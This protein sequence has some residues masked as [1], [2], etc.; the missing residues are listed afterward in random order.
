MSDPPAKLDADSVRAAW[1]RAA[2]AYVSGQSSGRD[3]YRGD[4]FGPIQAALCGDVADL[5]LLDVG[6]GSGY[7]AREM[8]RRGAR[9]TA[10][11]ISPRMIEHAR[12][13]E[14]L[15][16]LSI[17]YEVLD[18]AQIATVWPAGSFDMATS[19]VALQ[20]MANVD[21]VLSAVHDVLRPGGRFVASITHPCTTTPHRTWQRD[22]Q[23][24]KRWLC[25]DRYFDRVPF[26]FA[27]RGWEYD[28][29]TIG[30]HAPL[31][32][33]FDWIL[34]A[35]FALRAFREPRPG[36][37]ALRLHPDLEDAS[38]VPY[39]AIFDLV[40]AEAGSRTR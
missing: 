31:E 11:D 28:F 33:W 1:D 26:E 3:Y 4:F 22:E 13:L 23:G 5:G 10:I 38:R 18:A 20:D 19:C 39:Y 37:E 25:I 9:V 14:A 7:F 8:A 32:D 29:E 36:R 2:N 6:C 24:R 17:A 12:R 21:R 16:P 15:T 35:G 30:L 40:C 34:D 27:W